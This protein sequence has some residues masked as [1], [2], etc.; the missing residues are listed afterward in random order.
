MS[1]EDLTDYLLPTTFVQN[2]PQAVKV[3]QVPPEASI[4]I[5]Y[6]SKNG[7]EKSEISNTITTDTV[8]TIGPIFDVESPVIEDLT[9]RYLPDFI[10]GDYPTAFAESVTDYQEI[11]PLVY[12]TTTYYPDSFLSITSTANGTS[13]SQL[14]VKDFGGEPL[15][16]LRYSS[17]IP[18]V[19][20]FIIGK[21]SFL[22]L[23][24]LDNH[25]Y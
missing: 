9:E 4:V 15:L 21:L 16:S 14:A 24:S 17:A 13:D 7:N 22:S 20:F 19:A 8:V 1:A 3:S 23:W 12:V 25:G 5:N 10:N 6:P 2:Y 18:F 11:S